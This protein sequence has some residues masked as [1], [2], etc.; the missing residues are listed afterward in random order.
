MSSESV[1]EAQDA[2]NLPKLL[3]A[4][5][6]GARSVNAL[7]KAPPPKDDDNDSESEDEADD[8]F[9]YQMAFSEFKNICLDSRSEVASLLNQSLQSTASA[10]NMVDDYE[11]D[12]PVL[13]ETAAEACDILLERV[14]QYIQNEKEG[15]I[16][17]DGENLGEIVR[18]FARNRGGSGFDQIVGSLVDMEVSSSILQLDFIFLVKVSL[19]LNTHLSLET[20]NYKRSKF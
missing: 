8:E 10:D 11:F 16:G 7:P 17:R 14:D 2:P 9:A 1:K 13:W 4:L 20:T 15:R 19:V 5:A 18:D 12:D 6:A 3:A